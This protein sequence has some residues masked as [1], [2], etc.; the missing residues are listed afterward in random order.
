MK[1]IAIIGTNGIPSNYGGFETLVEYLAKFLSDTYRITV[2]CSLKSRNDKPRYYRGCK[3][4]YINLNANNWQSIPYDIISL[5][6]SYKKFDKI[7]ILGASG[8]IAM[9]LFFN[10]RSK[11]IIN[12]GG[13]D[14]QRSK[15]SY[16]TRKLIK[17]SERMSIMY[18]SSIISDNLEIQK[19][20]KM[21][22]NRNSFLIEYGG[23]HVK[24]V[25]P[26]NSDYHKY[27]FLKSNYAFTVARIQ[28][29]NNI[30][31]LLDSFVHK[32]SIPIVFVGNWQNSKYGIR[33]KNKYNHYQNIILLDAIYNQ[34]ELNLLRSNCK[35]YLHGHSAGGTNPALVE[36]M[37][38]SLPIF[39][40]DCNFNRCTTANKAKYF[41]NSNDLLENINK[42]SEIEL[43][44]L[45][46]NMAN[47]AKRLYKWEII[48][49]KYSEVFER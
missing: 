33:M 30:E 28:K 1:K 37:C 5:F 14:W 38:L 20:L 24:H 16:F 32:S 8:G 13:L 19:Y 18:S 7:L 41:S 26:Q 31:L 43:N 45:G 2:F 29:D 17:Y 6:K 27:G 34:R 42:T 4:V 39:A 9:P 23:D 11:F 36:A 22:Y 46:N 12:L 48:T 21:K 47:Y 49:N 3:L 44:I 40:Y 35:I 25:N 15:W 10:Y